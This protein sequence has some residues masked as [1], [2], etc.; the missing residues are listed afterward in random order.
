VICLVRRKAMLLVRWP[1]G[2]VGWLAACSS[3][4][5]H[6][7]SNRSHH[8]AVLTVPRGQFDLLCFALLCF[9]LLCCPVPLPVLLLYCLAVTT[10]RIA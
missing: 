1:L 5:A 6:G 4:A 3:N 7:E 10:H 8:D 9:V 2:A